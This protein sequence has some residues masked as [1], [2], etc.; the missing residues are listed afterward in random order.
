MNN[1]SEHKKKQKII[2]TT[3]MK[4]RIFVNAQWMIAGR[5]IQMLLSLIVGMISTRY[6]GP[7]NY[8]L[9]NYGQAFTNFFMCVCTLGI[10]S[11]I[12]KEF[13]DRPNEQ[14]RSLGTSIFF[15][16]ISSIGAL[17]LVCGISL[18]V[19]A[20]KM[21]TNLV[22]FLC[23]VSLLFHPF[24]TINYWFQY[25]YMSKVTALATF[26]S[27]LVTSIYKV[28]LLILNK[29][30]YWFA[31]A[32]TVDYAFL[33]FFLVIAYK[34]HDG[35]KFEISISRGRSILQRSYH[36]IMSGMMSAI[37]S[38]TDKLMLKHMLGDES[39]GYYSTAVTLCGI[40]TFILSAIIDVMYPVILESFSRSKEE[41]DKKN[42]QLYTIIFYL[43][44]FV[45]SM[46]CVLGELIVKLL[47]GNKYLPAVA[48]L[49]V[50]TWYTAFSYF[51]VARGAWMVCNN[52]QK[53]LKYMYVGAAIINSLINLLLIPTLGATG[54]A[55]ASLLTQIF[56]SMLLP[57][58]IKDL[59]PNVKLMWEAI[60]LKDL[61]SSIKTHE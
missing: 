53:Y 8:G 33:A 38:Q 48:P 12:I 19:N 15:R 46:F 50:V 60:L 17:A 28:I 45:S 16:C 13:V 1:F 58:C 5:V 44:V 14:G 4:N 27:Y 25:K 22:V 3:F 9:V 26:F 41:F 43:S 7:T 59:R 51:G 34:K 6:L 36:Y 24:D 54:A 52:H 10:N 42:R 61:R 49:K 30:V 29:S 21:E 40:W 31:L 18:L 35:P 57:M 23:A 2:K 55:V 11:V 37:Y 32:T 39:V 56:T 20:G 47:Y